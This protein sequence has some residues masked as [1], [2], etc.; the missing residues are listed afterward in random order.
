MMPCKSVA[1]G[2]AS[3]DLCSSDAGDEMSLRALARR[4]LE[5]GGGKRMETMST[6]GFRLLEF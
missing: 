4:G 3:A 5:E 2:I 6:W 1:M